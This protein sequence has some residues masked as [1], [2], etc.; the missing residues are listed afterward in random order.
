MNIVGTEKL[1][2]NWYQGNKE[3]GPK[4][5]GFGCI[6][7]TSRKIVVWYQSYILKRGYTAPISLQVPASPQKASQT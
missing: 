6:K 3:N 5:R 2:T 7:S 1:I 4:N